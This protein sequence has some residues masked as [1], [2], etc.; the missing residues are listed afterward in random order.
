MASLAKFSVGCMN[1]GT[2]SRFEVL[3]VTSYARNKTPV[4][5]IIKNKRRSPISLCGFLKNLSEE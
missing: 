5:E 2:K 3:I 4:D 1:E